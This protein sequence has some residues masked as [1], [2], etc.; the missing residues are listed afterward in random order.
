[1]KNIAIM[2]AQLSGGGAEAVRAA[3]YDIKRQA[4]I[5]EALYEQ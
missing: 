5:L 4:K 1:M 3:G 2:I